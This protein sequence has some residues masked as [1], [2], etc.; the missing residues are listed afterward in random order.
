MNLDGSCFGKV[1]GLSRHRAHPGR[2]RFVIDD[3]DLPSNLGDDELLEGKVDMDL[4]PA[5]GDKA[6]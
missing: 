5:P 6:G 2:V 4:G 1:E 3:G